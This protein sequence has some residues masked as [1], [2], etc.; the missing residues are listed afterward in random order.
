MEPEPVHVSPCDGASV[1]Q[2]RRLVLR[3]FGPD[4]APWLQ[5]LMEIADVNTNTLIIPTPCPPGFAK[6]WIE[7]AHRNAREGKAFTFA[8]R[9]AD[10]RPMGAI[11]LVVNAPHAHAEM[12]YFL[13]PAFW[14]K[15]Y[16]S[17]ASEAMLRL[18][19]GKLGLH[20]VFAVHFGSNPA[21]GKVMKKVG[22][23][24]EGRRREHVRKCDVFLDLEQYA[25]LRDEW[26]EKMGSA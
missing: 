20:R 26:W 13:D 14:N 15:G 18:A 16:C 10:L 2:T 4:D 11:F 8:M 25:I 24:Y 6:E 21:S 1:L 12:G 17:E 9:D 23:V 22:M 5:A 3:P 19:F 7:T